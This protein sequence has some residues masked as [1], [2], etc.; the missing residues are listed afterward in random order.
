MET[1]DFQI[2]PYLDGVL[3]NSETKVAEIV[4]WEMGGENIAGET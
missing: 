3:D 1:F 2:Q 4:Q